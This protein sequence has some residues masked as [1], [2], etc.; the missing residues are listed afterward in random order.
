MNLLFIFVLDDFKRLKHMMRYEMGVTV[1]WYD[2]GLELLDGD[3]V[4]LDEIGIKYPNDVNKCCTEMFKKWLQCKPNADWDQ[5]VTAL[6]E[7]KLNAAAEN[8][9]S[10]FMYCK[11]QNNSYSTVITQID[12]MNMFLYQIKYT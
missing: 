4:A 11:I 3:A 1:E 12:K 6:S 8:I 10:E 9:K 2:I 5:L 7:L